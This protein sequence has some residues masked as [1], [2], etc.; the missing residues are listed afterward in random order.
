MQK[1][2]HPR[3]L[4]AALGALLPATTSVLPAMPV[5]DVCDAIV[6]GIGCLVP[7]LKHA[8]GSTG[9]AEVRDAAKKAYILIRK[10]RFGVVVKIAR[11]QLGP[12]KK[13]DLGAGKVALLADKCASNAEL[14]DKMVELR[15][16][17]SAALVSTAKRSAVAALDALD[18]PKAKAVKAATRSGGGSR[19]TVWVGDPHA[20]F[21]AS[22]GR[23]EAAEEA[24]ATAPNEEEDGG[25]G[26]AAPNAKKPLHLRVLDDMRTEGAELVAKYFI[27]SDDVKKHLDSWLLYSRAMTLPPVAP[28]FPHA[29]VEAVEA[30]FTT[31]EQIEDFWPEGSLVRS[32]HLLSFSRAQLAQAASD[33]GS[34]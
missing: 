5:A 20:L 8:S 21:V 23:V 10:K 30:Q 3:V 19:A 18:G 6:S 17:G 4:K 16:A 29:E 1:G 12:F 24:A 2:V 22:I 13:G 26:G 14:V 11:K 28:D 32:L 15:E 25:A 34:P 31:K 7:K 27:G 33:G 9:R